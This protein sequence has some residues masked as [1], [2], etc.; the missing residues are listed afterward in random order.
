MP[1]ST[2]GRIQL[3]IIILKVIFL[4]CHHNFACT[5]SWRKHRDS[6][7]SINLRSFS[8]YIRKDMTPSQ[9]STIFYWMKNLKACPN[10]TT[11]VEECKQRTTRKVL[12]SG[13]LLNLPRV[14]KTRMVPRVPIVRAR[15]VLKVRT[16]PPSKTGSK[17][18]HG[19][20]W[21][22]KQSELC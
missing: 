2:K 21:S 1:V 5:R 20:T 17:R 9:E 11:T 3:C 18:Q 15:P 8:T 12:P 10:Q 13:Y 6:S 4:T 22:T 16:P 19:N 14:M 7:K